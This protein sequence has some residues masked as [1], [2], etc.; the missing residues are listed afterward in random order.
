MLAGALLALSVATAP[1][2]LTVSCADATCPAWTA[3]AVREMQVALAALPEPLRSPPGGLHFT[4]RSRPRPLGMG[5]GNDDAPTWVDGSFQL[6]GFLDAPNEP[7]RWREEG[8]SHDE[9]EKLWWRRALVHAVMKKQDDVQRWSD[10]TAWRRMSGWSRGVTGDSAANTYAGGY[11]RTL[12]MQSAQLDFVTFAEEQ[13]VPVESIRPDL[14]RADDRASCQRPSKARAFHTLLFDTGFTPEPWTRPSCPS[15]E[16][17]A[18]LDR[19]TSVELL[20]VASSGKRPESLFGHL[21]LRPVHRESEF[22]Q[23]PSFESA[24]QIAAITDGPSAG[25]IYLWR[26]LTG[27]Y[28]TAVL[29]LSWRDFEREV[30]NDEQRMVRRFE[31]T[32]SARERERLMERVFELERRGYFTYWF[33]TSN[34]ATQAAELI[35][36]ALDEDTVVRIPGTLLASPSSA[37][38][39]LDAAEVRDGQTTRKLL[40][41]LHADFEPSSVIADRA[42]A[43]RR[44]L[45]QELGH[46]DFTHVRSDDPAARREAWTRIARHLPESDAERAALSEWWLATARVERFR[47]DIA[48]HDLRKLR[49]ATLLPGG[50]R[51]SAD[52]QV[53][54][55]QEL[56]ARESRLA[57]EAMELDRADAIAQR[58]EHAPR[59]A[60]TDGEREVEAHALA[61]IDAFDQVTRLHGEIVDRDQP[62]RSPAEL[63]AREHASLV[64]AREEWSER[65]LQGSGTWRTA[66]GLGFSGSP[67]LRIESS[68]MRELLGDQR[69]RGLQASTELH[70]LDGELTL[71]REGDAPH[72]QR[73]AFTLFGW[74]SLGQIS[75]ALRTSTLEWFGYGVH[76]TY[77]FLDSRAFEHRSR[78]DAEVYLLLDASPTYERLLALGLGAR[79]QLG[80]NGLRALDPAAGPRALITQRVPLGGHSANAFRLDAAYVPT[81]H[82]G[83]G[84]A[85]DAELS[86]QLDLRARLFGV[87][88]LLRPEVLAN[89]NVATGE[90]RIELALM[91]EP[92]P[93]ED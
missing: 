59:R 26:G 66:V 16:G 4:A 72:V 13:F 14:V 53:R 30:L 46:V 71:V 41:P 38:D 21:L 39:G 45:E 77:D 84:L 36:S 76:A 11:S 28:Q 82:K 48:R 55:R 23:G 31:L 86:A 22:V 34:C 6:Y 35:E 93:G 54:A 92:L 51:I 85:H 87:T 75:P 91:F 73:S 74:R 78:I 10:R 52:D 27:G 70:V 9:R 29:T 90:R 61:E 44:E 2:G 64:R 25:P 50:K 68:G 47:V 12:G 15:F 42:E 58:N 65:A 83:P 60:L 69:V 57:F 37:L 80:F 63:L 17:W 5:D 56:F 7:E 19:L 62:N 8:L 40:R 88:A 1:P 89:V 33:L 79:A 3:E 81:F 20:L 32:L 49:L 43:Q 18:A 67:S 24:I